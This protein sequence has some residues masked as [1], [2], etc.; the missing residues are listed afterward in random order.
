[1]FYK[2]SSAAQIKEEKDFYVTSRDGKVLFVRHAESKNNSDDKAVVL[3]HGITGNPNEYIHMYA[4]NFFT[5]KG[6]DVYRMSFYD[7]ADNAR[8]LHT[9]TLPLQANDLNDVIE[10]VKEKHEKVFSCGHSYGGAT[11]LFANPDVN[12]IAFWDSSF[13]VSCFWEEFKRD[14]KTFDTKIIS[15]SNRIDMLFSKEMM[16]HAQSH[17]EQ[18]MEDLSK[19]ISSPSTV[20]TAEKYDLVEG[21]THLFEHLT[22]TKEYHEIKNA[23]HRFTNGDTAQDLLNVTHQWFERF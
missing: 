23:D 20:I 11:T 15:I 17:T 19:S 3:A 5:E 14:E 22:C 2:L 21:G 8:K 1:M 16:E 10:H 7:D 6:Y 18:D 13:D 9:T 12:A 4:R